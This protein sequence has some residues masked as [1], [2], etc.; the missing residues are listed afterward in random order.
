M[1]WPQHSCGDV[2]VP[3]SVGI[4]NGEREIIGTCWRRNLRRGSRERTTL[5]G[6]GDRH[7]G[8]WMDNSA[9][10]AVAWSGLCLRVS[11]VRHFRKPLESSYAYRKSYNQQLGMHVLPRGAVPTDTIIFLQTSIRSRCNSAARAEETVL[12]EKIVLGERCEFTLARARYYEN[13]ASTLSPIRVI[14]DSP[15]CH[16]VPFFSWTLLSRQTQLFQVHQHVGGIR[17]DSKG[18]RALQVFLSIAATIA[19]R[20]PARS[21]GRRQA[22]PRRCR[23]RQYNSQW[24]SVIVVR[25]LRKCRVKAWPF[26]H[27]LP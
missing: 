2:T 5:R 27:H 17:V 15:N 4:G 19:I 23:P 16:S 6:P 10:R 1:R 9:V 7:R 22:C 8:K 3:P 24:R 20:L 18:A 11:W 21:C 14:P 12:Y 25:Q 26:Q 13:T